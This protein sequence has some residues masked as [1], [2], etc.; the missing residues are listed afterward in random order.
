[1]KDIPRYAFTLTLVALI[2]AGS[3]SWVNSITKPIIL[4]QQSNNLKIG[5][6]QVLP[7]TEN[8]VIEPVK[9]GKE[10]LY[11]K[12]FS[13]KE[14]T[15]MIGYAFLVFSQGYSSTIQTLVGIDTTGIIQKINILFQQETPGLGTRC[16]EIL[17]GDT[18]P[19]WQAQFTDKNALSLALDMDGGEIQTITGATIT[20]RVITDAI[21]ESA[22]SVFQR[23]QSENK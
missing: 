11:Y 14:K 20:S 19:W 8:G 5:L 3:L 15:T 21:V 22:K 18:E 10:I 1:M 2:A 9:E 17:S 13:N 6:Y 16:Q 12:G 7:G 4:E 23:I